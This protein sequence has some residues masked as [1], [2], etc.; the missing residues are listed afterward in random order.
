MSQDRKPA[1]AG[2]A[3][4][5]GFAD[6]WKTETGR[7]STFVYVVLGIGVFTLLLLLAVIYFSASER[8][9]TSP[10]ICT[11]IS[12]E[13][14]EAAVL[15][16]N[17]DRL[18]VVYDETP[19]QPA[20]NRFGPVLAKLD[21]TDGTCSNLPQGVANQEVVYAISGVIAFYNQTSEQQQVEIT[22]Q[23]S[24]QL[25]A[26]LFVVP[27]P[28]PDPS[29]TPEPTAEPIESPAVVASPMR[30]SSP[31]VSASPAATPAPAGSPVP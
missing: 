20:S 16:G 23:P 24:G 22:Y 19:R 29:P 27:T 4:R 14:A 30:D 1:D 2:S 26:S 3:G 31:D 6:R 17:V 12:R 7:P 18:T 28:T 21:Y 8:E 10:P 11:D 5:A 25:D 13:D 15:A 9:R